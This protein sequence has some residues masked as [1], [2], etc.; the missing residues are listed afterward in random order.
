MNMLTGIFNF[1][2]ES[3]V[4]RFWYMSWADGDLMACL[5][6]D[7]LTAPWRLTYRFR[8]YVDNEAF[9]SADRKSTY[10]MEGLDGDEATRL[11]M[12]CVFEHVSA[13]VA[14]ANGAVSRS[15]LVVR[16]GAKDAMRLLA[17]QPWSH[18]KVSAPEAKTPQ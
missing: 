15:C 2:D 16:G 8:Y 1:T 12:A 7:S 3:Y 14:A 10:E 17:R 13:L 4:D 18:V 5:Y 9:D 6:R 11:E